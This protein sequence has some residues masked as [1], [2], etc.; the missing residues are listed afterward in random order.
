LPIIATNK[1]IPLINKLLNIVTIVCIPLGKANGLLASSSMAPGQVR[2]ANA[3]HF[4]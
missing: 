1:I 4:E 3:A 2:A